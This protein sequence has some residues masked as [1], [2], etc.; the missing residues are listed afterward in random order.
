MPQSLSLSLS[1]SLT[2]TP[3]IEHH[4]I[5]IGPPKTDA[6]LHRAHLGAVQQRL[7]ERK[8]PAHRHTPTHITGRGR[9]TIFLELTPRE[10]EK[11]KANS[12]RFNFLL[13]LLRAEDGER[14]EDMQW[15]FVC[16]G[17]AQRERE[18]GGGERDGCACL[19]VRVVCLFSQLRGLPSPH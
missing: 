9:T 5:C 1:L 10:K 19:C 6:Y 3:G 13:K 15:R 18:R 17:L 8:V 14:G 11:R 2:S 7:D 16:F 12:L 4:A